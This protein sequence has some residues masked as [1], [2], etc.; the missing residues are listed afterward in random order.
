M[1]KQSKQKAAARA[2]AIEITFASIHPRPV[3]TLA[4]TYAQVA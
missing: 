2:V 3:V 4:A 1:A